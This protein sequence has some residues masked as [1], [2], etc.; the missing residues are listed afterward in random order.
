MLLSWST[1]AVTEPSRYQVSHM[2]I[3]TED[4]APLLLVPSL[5]LVQLL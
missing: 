5:V 3:V 1:C 4:V 2:H